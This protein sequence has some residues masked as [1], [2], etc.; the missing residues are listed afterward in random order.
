MSWQRI[1][2]YEKQEYWDPLVEAWLQFCEPADISEGIK[3]WL[4]NNLGFC[5]ER[6]NAIGVEHLKEII[7]E[8][9]FTDLTPLGPIG[10]QLQGEDVMDV[11]NYIL[12]NRL[13]ELHDN[14]IWIACQI[15]GSPFDEIISVDFVTVS[16]ILSSGNDGFKEYVLEN[17]QSIFTDYIS[18][19]K[20]Q[21]D[22]TGLVYILN[23][24]DIED[25]QKVEYLR[26]QTEHKVLDVMDIND[27]YKPLA[28][29]GK[30]LYPCWENVLAYY[31]F[32]QE[33]I[34]DD[35]EGF[36]NENVDKLLRKDYPTENS[37][38]FASD[39]VYKSYLNIMAFEKLLPVLIQHVGK[40]DEDKFTKETGIE[41]AK[42]LVQNN[43][44]TDNVKTAKVV[45]QFGA[46]LFAKYLSFH[47]YSLI[48]NFDGYN[49]DSKTLSILLD[50]SSTL[51]NGQH[52]NLA[53]KVP[54]ELV[55]QDS[56]L[57]NV[58]MAL[59]IKRKEELSW[60][61]VEAVLNKA[62]QTATKKQFQEWLIKRYLSDVN[63]EKIILKSMRYPYSEIVDDT[64]RPL[65][66]KEFKEYLDLLAPLG[67]FTSNK[68]EEKGYRVYHS[69]KQ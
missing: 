4:N 68:E 49:V 61:V 58:L 8:C 19:S 20:G 27:A 6:L 29:R 59:M 15:T 63:K 37:S 69:T 3:E 21:E 65:V 60:P 57:A 42:L 32:D 26:W 18:K 66:P 40:D 17:L 30:V 53:K 52:W 46:P 2:T 55:K 64:K 9:M 38:A 39:I 31:T 62:T 5:I 22:E 44:L 11:A 41:R 1:Q 25:N 14:N 24:E 7:K 51:T 35:L 13:F 48:G 12:E 10:G 54:A 50:K 67:L 34:S 47:I 56:D 33:M 45:A 43:Y 23:C 28:I 36:I 16:D